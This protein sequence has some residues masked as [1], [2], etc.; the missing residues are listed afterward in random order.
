MSY[1]H[2]EDEVNRL[3]HAVQT[4]EEWQRG[5][6][7]LLLSKQAVQLDVNARLAHLSARLDASD[8]RMDRVQALMR[9]IVATL[10]E[11]LDT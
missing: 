9:G 6:R 11:V 2:L 8:E 5:S 10:T 3:H 1:N 7:G 4:L